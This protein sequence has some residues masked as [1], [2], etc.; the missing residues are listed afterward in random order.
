M[1]DQH[2]A[3][4]AQDF[5]SLR[6]GV[7]ALVATARCYKRPTSKLDPDP[8]P[9]GKCAACLARLAYYGSAE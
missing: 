2:I 9:C 1:P 7:G 8:G 3:A 6:R 5:E 4:P